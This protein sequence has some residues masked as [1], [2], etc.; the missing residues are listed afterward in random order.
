MKSISI[1]E[2]GGGVPDLRQ[3]LEKDRGLLV[4]DGDTPLGVLYAPSAESL[5]LCMDALILARGKLAIER[6]QQDAAE[7]GL[8]KWTMDDVNAFIAK[9]RQKR[10]CR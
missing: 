1:Q 7:R 3:Q 5:D 4:T 6:L 8:D 2:V 9:V 10:D